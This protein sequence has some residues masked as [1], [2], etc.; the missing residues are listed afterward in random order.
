MTTC[1]F[2]WLYEHHGAMWIT[3]V[4]SFRRWAW[5]VVLSCPVFPKHCQ[6]LAILVLWGCI[7]LCVSY[8]RHCAYKPHMLHHF[9]A[10][11]AY[12]VLLEMLR[13]E[14]QPSGYLASRPRGVQMVHLPFPQF[15]TLNSHWWPHFTAMT[16][17]IMTWLM[18]ALSTLGSPRESFSHPN[19][20]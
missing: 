17:H 20:E 13:Q 1:N 14:K 4:K 5:N 16:W 7:C 12:I 11:P 15:W 8:N 3:I 10:L 18:N 9:A 6:L 2:W 19:F